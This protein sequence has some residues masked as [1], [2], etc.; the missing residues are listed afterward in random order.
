MRKQ[1][2]LIITEFWNKFCD[3]LLSLNSAEVRRTLAVMAEVLHCDL[4]VSEIELLSH[5]NVH[6]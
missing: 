5:D 2:F 3:F 1:T 4:D 6:F